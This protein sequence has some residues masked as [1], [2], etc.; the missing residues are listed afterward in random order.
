M[1]SWDPLSPLRSHCH[2]PSC[3]LYTIATAP[4]QA[5]ATLAH[6]QPL[7]R[8]VSLPLR[9]AALAASGCPLRAP[10]SRPPLRASRYKWL[11]PWAT[12]APACDRLRAASPGSIQLTPYRGTWLESVTPLHGA[13]DNH[14]CR[15]PSYGQ[16]P[17]LLAVFA[18]K[19]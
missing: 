13:M 5:V 6:R 4:S 14:P 8:S 2:N 15:W 7:L 12:A 10:Y 11:C 3:P 9:A 18:T 19:T 17:L 1:A 16:L